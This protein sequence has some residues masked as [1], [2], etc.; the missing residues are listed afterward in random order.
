MTISKQNILERLRSGETVELD[1]P[2]FSWLLLG[3]DKFPEL[4]AVKFNM[5]IKDGKI[6]LSPIKK[7]IYLNSAKLIFAGLSLNILYGAL[8]KNR[9]N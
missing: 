6:T 9:S 4:S 5:K 8:W 1:F 7:Q 2:E 3:L